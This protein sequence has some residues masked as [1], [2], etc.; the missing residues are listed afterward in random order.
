MNTIKLT[1]GEKIEDLIKSHNIDAST[2]ALET[3][4]SKATISDMIR[5][6][7]KGYDYRY[8]LKIARY[9]NVST[10]YLLG[11]TDAPTTDADLRYI[12]DYTGFDERTIKTLN[13]LKNS[14]DKE[15]FN[16]YRGSLTKSEYLF[17]LKIMQYILI[18]IKPCRAFADY[19]HALTIDLLNEEK[20]KNNSFAEN[21]NVYSKDFSLYKI[22]KSITEIVE[23]HGAKLFEKEFFSGAQD[24]YYIDEDLTDE[25]L[26][27][28]YDE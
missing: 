21:Y 10:D 6:V 12:C 2:L 17:F 22:T 11:L 27:D 3:G 16:I 13:G 14:T 28:Y 18:S 25:D 8:F 24:E 20:E 26:R 1:M 9:F 19:Y 23:N 15:L 4:I 5:N 7:D